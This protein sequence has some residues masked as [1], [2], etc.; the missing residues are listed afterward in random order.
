MVQ[1]MHSMMT[2][3]ENQRLRDEQRFREQARR[4]AD[5]FAWSAASKQAATAPA[6]HEQPEQLGAAHPEQPEQLGA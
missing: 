3:Y 2:Q 4:D 5:N 1:D 6:H